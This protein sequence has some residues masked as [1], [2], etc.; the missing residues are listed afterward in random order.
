MQGK[1]LGSKHQE[2]HRGQYTYRM[3]IGKAT[4]DGEQTSME[5]IANEGEL[6]ACANLGYAVLD[7]RMFEMNQR[8]MMSMKLLD[9][10]PVDLAL[11]VQRCIEATFGRISA[12]QIIPPEALE[13]KRVKKE[14]EIV[15][16]EG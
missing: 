14:P 3:V 9:D 4:G 16:G 15:Q 13:P 8:M 2:L 12:D 5:I 1:A 10:L 7:N 11:K 6:P